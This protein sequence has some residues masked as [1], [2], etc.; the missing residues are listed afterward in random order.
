MAK[1]LQKVTK[2]VS[3]NVNSNVKIPHQTYASSVGKY[4]GN[5][6]EKNSR[7]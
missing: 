1:A 3:K 7:I 4:A 5:N 6:I 2:T